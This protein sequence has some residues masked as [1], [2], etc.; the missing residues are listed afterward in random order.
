MHSR[1]VCMQ[2][3]KYLDIF[4]VISNEMIKSFKSRC[5][6]IEVNKFLFSSI[7]RPTLDVKQ[8][9]IWNIQVKD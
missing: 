7:A 2:S 3:L 6:R 5:S 4:G 9:T 8:G 1:L